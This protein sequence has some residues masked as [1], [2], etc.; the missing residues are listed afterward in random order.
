MFT[1][2]LMPPRKLGRVEAE[3]LKNVP[4]GW[5]EIVAVTREKRNRTVFVLTRTAEIGPAVGAGLASTCIRSV[6]PANTFE[7]AAKAA[8]SPGDDGQNEL[9]PVV[10]TENVGV[11]P[12]GATTT[13]PPDAAVSTEFP[14]T[15][16]LSDRTMEIC[17]FPRSVR[18]TVPSTSSTATLSRRSAS[19]SVMVPSKLRAASMLTVWLARRQVMF[20][21]E[22]T[23]GSMLKVVLELATAV[24]VPF[25]SE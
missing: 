20:C 5:M 1:K 24:I 16:V 22:Q 15:T 9:K 25:V 21:A 7:R 6:C 19:K 23:V 12:S 4:A 3:T 13:V 18:K 14:L 10:S 8:M 2:P 11:A 17:S